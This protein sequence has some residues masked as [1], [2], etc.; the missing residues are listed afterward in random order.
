MTIK[1]TDVAKYY[2]NLDHQN[3]ALDFLQT[4][5]SK[6]ILDEFSKLYRNEE[7]D[8]IPSASE[9]A[10]RV[11]EAALRLIKEFEG[12]S[13][14][15]YPDPLS[16]ARP[17]TIGYGSTRK[18]DGSPFKMGDK[19]TKE[20]AEE[21]LVGSVEKNYLPSIEKI[22]YW[23]EMNINQRSALISFGYNLGTNFYGSSGFNTISKCLKEKR[24]KDVPAAM[25]LYVNPGSSV[26]AGLRRRRAAEGS[27]WSK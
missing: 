26:E 12:L 9:A 8:D 17:Y 27:L 18:K 21:L 13:L 23:S 11:P 6:E 1:L 4:A 7:V 24:W 15:A 22:P 19:I 10:S 16:N 2:K 14:T 20:E 5:I 25:M 3:L